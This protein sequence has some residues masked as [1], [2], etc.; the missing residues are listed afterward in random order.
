[1]GFGS[2]IGGDAHYL[3]QFAVDL[4]GDFQFVFLGE[5]GIR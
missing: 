1:M 3:D 5:L 4:H 2:G